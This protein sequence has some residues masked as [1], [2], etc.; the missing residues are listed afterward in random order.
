LLTGLAVVAILAGARLHIVITTLY[1]KDNQ[2]QRLYNVLL[3]GREP[4]RSYTWSSTGP[5]FAAEEKTYDRYGF[6]R[7]AYSFG[8]MSGFGPPGE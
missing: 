1:L 4:T 6:R 8:G 5:I 3:P 2:Q 7:I